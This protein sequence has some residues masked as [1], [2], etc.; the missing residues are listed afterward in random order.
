MTVYVRDGTRA[1]HQPEFEGGYCETLVIGV[2]GVRR[3]L[4]VLNCYRK[5]DLDDRIFDCLLASMA[6]VHT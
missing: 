1:F 5:L 2:C 3:N 6:T 4:Y